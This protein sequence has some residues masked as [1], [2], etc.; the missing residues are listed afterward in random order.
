MRCMLILTLEQNAGGS[1]CKFTLSVFFLLS[2]D[3]VLKSLR[4]HLKLFLDFFENVGVNACFLFVTRL[5]LAMSLV[6][7]DAKDGDV[8]IA[9]V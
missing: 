1:L 5:S 2:C 8:M 6:D 4:R 7:E 3:G 9:V